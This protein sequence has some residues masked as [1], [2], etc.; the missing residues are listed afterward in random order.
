MSTTDDIG[1]RHMAGSRRAQVYQQQHP[2][3]PATLP[4]AGGSFEPLTDSDF[5]LPIHSSELGRL[6]LHV[7]FDPHSSPLDDTNG[8]WRSDFD[9]APSA[10][11][12]SQL[13][14][15]LGN[16][17]TD[18]ALNGVYRPMGVQEACSFMTSLGPSLGPQSSSHCNFLNATPMVHA[19][20]NVMASVS[21][22]PH[23]MQDFIDNDTLA[24]WSRAPTNFE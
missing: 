16:N 6:P 10:F 13:C 9:M 7:A 24:I 1:L 21:T 17:V 5:V 19:G 11:G 15:D 8:D 22:Q 3:I 14:P 18:R 4:N 23:P 12:S 2:F 20:G